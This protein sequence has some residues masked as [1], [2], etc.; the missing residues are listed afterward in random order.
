MTMETRRDRPPL[1]CAQPEQLG[2]NDAA[3]DFANE[4]SLSVDL[5]RP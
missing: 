1:N 3:S 5:L 4:V 2:S